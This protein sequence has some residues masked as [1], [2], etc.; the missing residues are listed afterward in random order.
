MAYLWPL[1]NTHPPPLRALPAFV[2][3]TPRV[4]SDSAID[5]SS[6]L[7]GETCIDSCGAIDEVTV[8]IRVL[9]IWS[10]CIV[11]SLHTP[12]LHESQRYERDEAIT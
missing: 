12:R 6:R 4:R 7:E 10:T 5:P 1:T 9:L 3:D 11:E 8:E 2:F